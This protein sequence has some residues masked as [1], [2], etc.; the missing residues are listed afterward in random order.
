MFLN[1]V[2]YIQDNKGLIKGD[3]FD[4][5]KDKSARLFNLIAPVYGLFYN[6]QRRRY[7]CTVKNYKRE[8]NISSANNVVDIGC[9]TGSL[10]SVL[11]ELGINVVGIDSAKKMLTFAMNMP[12]NK[13][14]EFIQAN[15]LKELPFNSKSFDIAISSYVA[16]GITREERKSMYCEMSR[17]T[18]NY[19][20]IHDYNSKKSFTTSIIERLEGGDYFNFIENAEH[21]MK[22]C[23]SEVRVI[24]VGKRANWYICK[25][26]IFF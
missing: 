14:V 19:V 5:A 8:I 10:C 26:R 24:N 13:G 7:Y 1:G 9:G 17:I 21:E 3:F 16:H 22:E 2:R 23:F 11:K 15:V 25:P 18:K 4:L 20:V 6:Y 12:E